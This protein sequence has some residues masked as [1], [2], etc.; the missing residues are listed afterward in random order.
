MT[1]VPRVALGTV[2]MAE[3][4]LAAEEEEAVLAAVAV[5]L[6]LSPCRQW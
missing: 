2:A 6:H 4:M 5:W 3:A 1:P